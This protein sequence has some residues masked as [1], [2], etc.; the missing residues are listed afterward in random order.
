MK[1]PEKALTHHSVVSLI[2]MVIVLM[3]ILSC[4]WMKPTSRLISNSHSSSEGRQYGGGEE[5]SDSIC[6]V[7][8][9]YEQQVYDTVHPLSDLLEHFAAVSRGMKDIVIFLLPTDATEPTGIRILYEHFRYRMNISLVEIQHRPSVYLSGYLGTF[10]KRHN[11][12]FHN[13][14]YR[15]TDEVIAMCPENFRWLLVTNGDNMYKPTFFDYLDDRYDIVAYDFYTRHYYYNSGFPIDGQN[16]V[17]SCRRLNGNSFLETSCLTNNLSFAHTDLGANVLNLRKFRLERRYYKDVIADDRGVSKDGFM[18]MSLVSSGWTVKFV[19]KHHSFGCLY[20]HNPNYQACV[21][22]SISSA[23]VASE[24]YCIDNR[25]REYLFMLGNSSLMVQEHVLDR[26]I[27][28][29]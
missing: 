12:D 20:S 26:C 14:I 23:W 29:V 16:R 3:S 1:P 17:E 8:R 22:H 11:R 24:E 4:T 27:S 21:H 10:R 7:V 28:I 13:A 15:M 6:I 9:T 25:N 2:F 5:K 18:M 19:R